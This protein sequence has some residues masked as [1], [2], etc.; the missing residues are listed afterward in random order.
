MAPAV[1]RHAATVLVVRDDPLRVLMVR[2]PPTGTFAS[3]L[4]FPGGGVEPDDDDRSWDELAPGNHDDRAALIAGVRETF[5]E[6]G[7]LLGARSAADRT[8]AFPDAVRRAGGLVL[9][10]IVPIARWVT[11]SM[12]PRRWD[13]RFLVA[14]APDGQEPVADGAE[15]LSA[16]WL[17]PADVIERADAGDELLPFPTRV[18]LRWLALSAHADDVLARARERTPVLIEPT[19]EVRAGRRWVVLPSGTGYDIAE[20]EVD[21]TLPG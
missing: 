16:D 3:A 18:H 21:M 2:R 8:G 12:A 15:A 17:R 1:P 14:R 9:D 11:P 6:V 4:V 19:V 20:A 5:E 13:T 7:L 10:D